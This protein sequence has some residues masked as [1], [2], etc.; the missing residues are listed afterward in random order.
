M[1]DGT[2]KS[3]RAW[4]NSQLRTQSQAD[5]LQAVA[6]EER[7]MM[8]SNTPNRKPHHRES[9]RPGNIHDVNG[10]PVLNVEEAKYLGSQVAW[11]QP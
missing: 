4:V 1:S 5:V 10:E 8:A 11:A 7:R 2:L 9:G 6:V 3:I